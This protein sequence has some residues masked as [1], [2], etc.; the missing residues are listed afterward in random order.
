[1]SVGKKQ[2]NL[3]IAVQHL[4]AGTHLLCLSAGKPEKAWL[5]HKEECPGCCDYAVRLW[6]ARALIQ[7]AWVREVGRADPETTIYEWVGWTA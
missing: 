1:M 4:I 7:Y 3:S 5:Q 2:L 6:V